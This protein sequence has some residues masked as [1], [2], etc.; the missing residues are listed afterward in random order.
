MAGMHR[1][2]RDEP[3]I[4][5]PSR[6]EV[7]AAIE[8]LP[9]DLNWDRMRPLLR[10][11]FLRRRPMPP[12]ADRPVTFHVPPGLK[13]CLGVDIGPAF[14][15]V[16]G[17]MLDSWS[18]T[19]EFAL[20][21][22]MDNLRGAIAAEKFFEMEYGTVANV[23]LWWYQSHGGLA[24]ALLLLENELVARY[25]PDPRLLIAP[26]RNLLIAAPYDADREMLEWLRD[27]IAVEDPNGLD[28]PVFE[29]ADGRL[30]FARGRSGGRARVH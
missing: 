10:P 22:A 25:G 7:R 8:G 15:Y 18:V 6:S 14:L 21:T 1:R 23:P 11:M 16:G 12:G 20:E 29:L 2:Q 3:A 5:G 17:E 24:S 27:E 19:S 9:D 13:I 26:M 30:S 4:V 28:L